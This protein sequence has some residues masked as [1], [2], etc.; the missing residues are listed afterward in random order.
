MVHDTVHEISTYGLNLITVSDDVYVQP[1]DVVGMYTGAWGTISWDYYDCG[2]SSSTTAYIATDISLSGPVMIP[3]A[4]NDCREYSIQVFYT[5]LRPPLSH[6][7]QYDLED[8]QH[9]DASFYI[10][11]LPE[12]SFPMPGTLFSWKLYAKATGT[13]Y[14]QVREET[15]YTSLLIYS[16]T[17]NTGKAQVKSQGFYNECFAGNSAR[18]GMNLYHT[19]ERDAYL[20]LE[21]NIRHD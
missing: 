20:I 11:L 9:I 12:L 15:T 16:S 14:L 6:Q 13:I 19:Y 1:G 4:H 2:G 3:T 5:T 7:L 17:R 10:I 8:R 21:V 18:T